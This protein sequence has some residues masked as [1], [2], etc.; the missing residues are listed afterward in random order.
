[1]RK[2]S[3]YFFLSYTARTAQ[4]DRLTITEGPREP[5]LSD[6]RSG[7]S[8][9]DSQSSLDSSLGASFWIAGGFQGLLAVKVEHSEGYK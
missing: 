8:E 6:D 3:S 7:L 1:M 5:D 9:I 4:Q 2:D